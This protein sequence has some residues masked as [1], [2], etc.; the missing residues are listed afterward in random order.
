MNNEMLTNILAQFDIES[1][2]MP[3]GN[4]HINDTYLCEPLRYI[5]QRI[6]TTIFKDPDGLMDNIQN[7]TDHLKRKIEAACGDPMRESLT[8]VPTVSGEKYYR[9]GEDVFRVY[10]F[11]S[12]TKTI[13]NDKT[14][15]DIY[16]A[17]V[18]FGRFGRMMDDF[19]V[20]LLHETIPDF[21]NTPKRVEAL[22]EAVEKNASGRAD[23][24]RKE[25]E[26]VRKSADL[27]S[28]VTDALASG[29]IP[30]RVTHNDTKINNIL[31]DNKT[32]KPVCVIDLD[33]IMPGSILYDFGDALR[34]GGST[35]AEDESDLSKVRFD[36]ESFRCFARGWLSEMKDKL[37]DTEIQLLPVSVRLMT[38]E[39]G[40]RFLTDHI[41][42]D[43]YFKIHRDG[44]NLDRARNQFRLCEELKEKKPELSR[45]I[46]E[47]LKE[48]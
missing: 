45:I 15:E 17:G 41:N 21:H 18:G 29:K 46:N 30:V 37:T 47:I 2:I 44:H 13:E 39:C 11:I 33:T 28:A 25:I 27:A 22:Y 5:L 20:E 32:G 19:P 31:F 48:G 23:D 7:V 1:D 35:A 4:G 8:I 26:F 6:N 12:D 43:V 10:Y 14:Y 3:Y 42:G 16:N 9:S 24:V 38:Y 40:V 34:M 36:T